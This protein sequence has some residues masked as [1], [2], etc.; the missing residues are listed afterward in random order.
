MM[1]VKAVLK[2]LLHTNIIKINGEQQ[3]QL[4]ITEEVTLQQCNS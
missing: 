4:R 1:F 2:N 3:S